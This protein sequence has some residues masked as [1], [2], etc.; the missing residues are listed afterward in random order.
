[1]GKIPHERRLDNIEFVENGTK[2]LELPRNHVYRALILK[3]SG[4]CST[5]ATA[6]VGKKSYAIQKLIKRIEIV[7][8]G[9]DTIKSI[10]GMFLRM[11]NKYDF[12]TVPKETDIGTSASTNYDFETHMI[13]PFALTR[14]LRPL[15]AAIDSSKLQTF[16]IR[17]T[18]GSVNDLY[19]TPNG[20][21]LS[22][23]KLEL[24]TIEYLGADPDFKALINKHTQ[25]QK[26]VTATTSE[27]QERL[28][29][30]VVYRRF[31]LYTEVDGVASNSV[32]NKIKLKSGTLVFKDISADMLKGN[33]KFFSGNESL[34]DGVYVLELITDGQLSEALNTKGMSSLEFIFDVTK[35]TGTNVIH[36]FPEIIEG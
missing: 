3:L 36:I 17:V 27:L 23:V 12:G 19:A 9:K 33:M 32:L 20:A 26:E 24:Q 35:Q 8:N 5:T 30:E 2:T 7:A 1:M 31:F 21:T 16:D 28:P 34:E 14:A 13:L 29:T 6:P 15:D 10:P 11:L 4:R 18:W 25:I 22:G